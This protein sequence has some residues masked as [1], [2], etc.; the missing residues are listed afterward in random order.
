L[1]I[2]RGKTGLSEEKMLVDYDEKHLLIKE[3]KLPDGRAKVI[4]K[5][6]ATGEITQK[7]K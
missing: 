7:I 6:K 4:L 1:E 2:W 5:N 3:E